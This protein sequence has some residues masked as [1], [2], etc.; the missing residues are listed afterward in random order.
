LRLPLGGAVERFHERFHHLEDVLLL[1][2]AQL[3]RVRSAD[4]IFCLVAGCVKLAA[5][6]NWAVVEGE[7]DAG[8]GEGMIL[9]SAIKSYPASVWLT[10]K[11]YVLGL[12]SVVTGTLSGIYNLVTNPAGTIQKTWQGLKFLFQHSDEVRSQIVRDFCTAWEGGPESQG[13]YLGKVVGNLSLFAYA[14][15][16]LPSLY[17]SVL[18]LP[19]AIFSAVRSFSLFAATLPGRLTA[20]ASTVADALRWE[21]I[22]TSIADAAGAVRSWIARLFA[23]DAERTN[24]VTNE[25]VPSSR[26]GTG[27]AVSIYGQGEATEA[28]FTDTAVDPQYANGRPLTSI[29]PNGSVS[30]LAIRDAP[31]SPAT[32]AELKRLAQHGARITYANADMEGF[33]TYVD[34]L[35]QTF[36]NARIVQFGTVIGADSVQRGVVVLEIP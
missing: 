35:R 31:L 4:C 17:R 34:Q 19:R 29:L 9:G 28:G 14:G 15:Q 30:D 27:R 25:G 7:H 21:T 20:F 24:L 3:T 16:S 23:G 1:G 36:P 22:S 10:A 18:N 6:S 32:R 13:N 33:Q 2:T 26:V 12:W 11:G 8:R 5:I